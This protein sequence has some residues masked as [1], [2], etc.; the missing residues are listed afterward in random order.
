MWT[1]VRHKGIGSAAGGSGGWPAFPNPS[2]LGFF[3]KTITFGKMSLASQLTE[4]SVRPQNPCF[5]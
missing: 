1:A 5:P 4:A 2:V 3:A